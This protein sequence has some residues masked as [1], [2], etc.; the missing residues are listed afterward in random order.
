MRERMNHEKLNIFLL[1][2][3]IFTITSV[4]LG[5]MFTEYRMLLF[6][7][8]YLITAAVWFH[9]AITVIALFDRLYYVKKLKTRFKKRSIK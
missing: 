3:I 2:Y 4:L 6:R 9:L 8:W 5:V 1:L 7:I